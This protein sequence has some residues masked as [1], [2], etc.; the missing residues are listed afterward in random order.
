VRGWLRGVYTTEHA[1]SNFALADT[2]SG[3]AS[4]NLDGKTFVVVKTVANNN[5]VLFLETSDTVETD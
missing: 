3:K 1:I 4:G 2:C 5:V